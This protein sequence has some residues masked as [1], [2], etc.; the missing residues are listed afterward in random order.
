MPSNR[1]TKNVSNGPLDNCEERIRQLY[2][3]MSLGKLKE[4][5]DKELGKTIPLSRYRRK[6][7]RLGLSKYQLKRDETDMLSITLK[8]M[9]RGSKLFRW[10]EQLSQA[11]VERIISRGRPPIFRQVDPHQLPRGYIVR[12]PTPERVEHFPSHVPF[13]DFIQAFPALFEYHTPQCLLDGAGISPRLLQNGDD[14]P[15]AGTENDVQESWNMTPL[16]LDGTQALGDT[17]LRNNPRALAVLQTVPPLS[18]TLMNCVPISA[19]NNDSRMVNLLLRRQLLFSIA[20]GFAGIDEFPIWQ[21]FKLLQGI[22]FQALIQLFRVAQGPTMRAIAQSMFKA[23]IESGNHTILDMILSCEA[24]RIDVNKE[25]IFVSNR[26]YTPVER[27]SILRHHETI[28][29]L[30]KHRAD[31]N[32]TYRHSSGFSDFSTFNPEGALEYAVNS[33]TGPTD[34]TF[35]LLAD[36]VPT[37]SSKVL[38]EIARHSERCFVHLMEHHIQKCESDGKEFSSVVTEVITKFSEQG[39]LDILGQ[40][41]D[42]KVKPSLLNKAAERGYAKLYEK[43]VSEYAF[44]PNDDTLFASIE[45]GNL[46]LVESL[47]PCGPS[48]HRLGELEYRDNTPLSLA[49]ERGGKEMINLLRSRGAFRCFPCW[50]VFLKALNAAEKTQNKE[51]LDELIKIKPENTDCDKSREWALKAACRTGNYEMAQEQLENKNNG[52]VSLIDALKEAIRNQHLLIVELLLCFDAYIEPQ[53]ITLAAELG[54]HSLVCTLLTEGAMP[55]REAL[56]VALRR[57]DET[58]A[59]ILLNAGADINGSQRPSRISALQVT[60]ELGNRDLVQNMLEKGADPNDRMALSIAY[61]TDLEVFKTILTAYKDRYNR[62]LRGFG[63]TIL[64]SAV[65]SQNLALVRTLL[66]HNVDAHGFVRQ[67]RGY[68]WDNGYRLQMVLLRYE[69]DEDGFVEQGYREVTPFGYAIFMD[70]S[71]DLGIVSAFLKHHCSP[72]VVVALNDTN[73]AEGLRTN[74]FLA[75]IET[76]NME[77]IRLLFREDEKVIHAPARGKARRTALQRAAEIGNLEMV[78][79]LLN[80]GADINEPPG[81]NSGATALQLAAIGGIG[82]IVEYL[83]DHGAN[84]NAPAAAWNGMTALVGAASRGRIDIVAILLNKGAGR[85]EDGDEQFK[86]ALNEAERYGH[87]PTYDYLKWRWNRQ[88]REVLREDF[89]MEEFVDLDGSLTEQLGGQQRGV[90]SWGDF[91]MDMDLDG[92]LTEQLDGQQREVL[93]EDFFMGEFVDLDGSLTEQLD[94]QQPASYMEDFA[95]FDSSFDGD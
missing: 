44:R 71:N 77:L 43:M 58:L 49:I 46:Q 11:Y 54:L 13:V 3:Q 5:I 45:G 31:L 29:V 85:G 76:G 1:V 2:R 89:S 8:R 51:L 21:P 81:R 22:T 4:T 41:G 52:A 72:S 94:G 59:D 90:F 37:I 63:S 26:T 30:L 15:A 56:H 27:A 88:Q 6:I 80:L 39:V 20:N 95:E 62:R 19:A 53:H 74:A 7:E 70:S 16:S 36:V 69:Y 40:L 35:E 9:P 60:A 32:R 93:R 84:V 86:K 24:T 66:E 79:L 50:D 25:M 17:S 73:T 92:S 61:Q 87:Y 42:L 10:G 82:Q 91:S 18:I 38:M 12:P 34:E 67:R 65:K 57:K 83:I 75:A 64:A 33:Y 48:I 28:K 55:E 14:T 78:K 68:D 23:C 47:L